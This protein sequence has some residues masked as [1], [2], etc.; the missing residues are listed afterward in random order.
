MPGWAILLLVLLIALAL[1]ALAAYAGR[2]RQRLGRNIGD[3][4]M[5]DLELEPEKRTSDDE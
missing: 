2:A 1:G 5:K 3:Q 4:H